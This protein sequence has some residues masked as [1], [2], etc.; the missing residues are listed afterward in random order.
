MSPEDFVTY[1]QAFALKKLGFDERC[2]HYYI[3]DSKSLREVEPRC[4]GMYSISYNF[5]YDDSNELFEEL[6]SAPTLA[7]AHQFLIS[8]GFLI[9]P[10]SMSFESWQCRVCKKG[11]PFNNS[12]LYEDFASYNEALSEGITE[13]LRILDN[14]STIE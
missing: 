9:V 10:Y 1:E 12:K 8:K 6:T 5:N 4:F 3:N 7:Q 2:T 11:K 13:C 14:E